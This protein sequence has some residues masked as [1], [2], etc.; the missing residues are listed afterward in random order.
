MH[1]DGGQSRPDEPIS[2]VNLLLSFK[3]PG[4][5]KAGV[6]TVGFR[7]PSPEPRAPELSFGVVRHRPTVLLWASLGARVAK[8][9]TRDTYVYVQGRLMAK[10]GC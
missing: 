6:P 10:R 4:K 3:F 1:T 9:P 5:L 7:D 2:D 8:V